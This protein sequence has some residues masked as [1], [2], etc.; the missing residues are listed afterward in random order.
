MNVSDALDVIH[1]FFEED[2]SVTS[3]EELES[4]TAIRKTVYESMYKTT[5]K[6][7]HKQ[8]SSIQTAGGFNAEAD[9]FYGEEITPF[10]PDSAPVRKQYVP[11]TDFVENSPLPFGKTLDAPL[12]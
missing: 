1:F 12:G 6:Y 3:A 2:L 7:G 10:N 4:K 8:S 11:P 5:Y 9:G